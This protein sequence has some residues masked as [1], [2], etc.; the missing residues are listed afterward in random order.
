MRRSAVVLI[1]LLPLV[2]APIDTR[3][4]DASFFAFSDV[5]GIENE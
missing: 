5:M 3:E 2:L 1:L 4:M